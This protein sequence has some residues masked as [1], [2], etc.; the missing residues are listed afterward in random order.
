MQTPSPSQQSSSVV[1]A[2]PMNSGPTVH[3]DAQ[4]FV[5]SV[6][7]PLQQSVPVPHESPSPAHGGWHTPPSQMP[8]QQSAPA[9]HAPSF[10]VHGGT[11]T[12]LLQRPLQQSAAP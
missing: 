4:V 1:H 12:P 11:Q 6:Q 9:L 7:I 10:T 8:L 5:V 3:C 2:G